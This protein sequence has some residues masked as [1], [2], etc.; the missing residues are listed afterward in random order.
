MYARYT[1]AQLAGVS[2]FVLAWVINMPTILSS[3]EPMS[4]WAMCVGCPGYYHEAYTYRLILR[5]QQ[6]ECMCVIEIT[7]VT[8]I[9]F[10]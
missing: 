2:E 3:L 8:I 7:V 10:L 6:R 5:R 1:Y 9:S 4:K